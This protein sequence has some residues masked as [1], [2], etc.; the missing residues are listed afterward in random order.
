VY[1]LGSIPQ[2]LR[3]LAAHW[4]RRGDDEVESEV[5]DRLQGNPHT[6]AEHIHVE[7]VD[8]VVVLTGQ[9]GSIVAAHAAGDEAAVPSGVVDV[10]NQLSCDGD[11]EAAPG[12]DGRR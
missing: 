10:S 4:V 1:P 11:V 9:V 8:G 12:E 2:P 7:V 6:R 3:R 5:I